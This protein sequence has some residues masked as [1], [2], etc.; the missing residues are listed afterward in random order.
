MGRELTSGNK[1][2]E[3]QGALCNVD[4]RT[5][6]PRPADEQ[7]RSKYLGG[8]SGQGASLNRRKAELQPSPSRLK[9]GLPQKANKRRSHRGRRQ[10]CSRSC[11][12]GKS[13]SAHS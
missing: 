13:R 11:S 9:S 2:K 4:T 5:R 8:S 6:H 3:D 7:P 12:A 10:T 1:L